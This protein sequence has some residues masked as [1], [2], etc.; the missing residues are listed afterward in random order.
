MTQ[1]HATYHYHRL[2]VLPVS[3]AV[4]AQLERQALVQNQPTIVEVNG[5][6]DHRRSTKAEAGAE[7]LAPHHPEATLETQTPASQSQTALVAPIRLQNQ[8]I[9]TIQL[10]ETERPHHWSERELALVEVVTEQMAQ[11]AENIRL[12]D[13]TRARA[14]REQ[15]I[16]EITDKLRAASS[17]EKLVKTAAEELG[18]RF[19]A[20]FALIELGV[21]TP[22]K[23]SVQPENAYK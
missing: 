15:S 22:A 7:N 14:A 1:P 10:Y 4:T 17:L 23:R 3:E 6:A 18:R 2:G 21:D 20:E 13:E 19:S 5:P 8:T 11:A 9:G 12:F 16:R